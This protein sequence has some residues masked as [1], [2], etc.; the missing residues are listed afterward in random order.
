MEPVLKLSYCAESFGY[1][2][3]GQTGVDIFKR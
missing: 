1:N 2:P 3:P